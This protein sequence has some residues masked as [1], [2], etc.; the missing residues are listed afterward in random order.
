V[1]FR[2]LVAQADGPGVPVAD[3]GVAVTVT[4]V[5]P[6][7]GALEVLAEPADVDDE[8]GEDAQPT[9][10]VMQQTSAAA[11]QPARELP[12]LAFTTV[13]LTRVGAS[14]AALQV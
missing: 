8:L 6:A 9:N 10:A 13:P 11:A 2:E 4:V 5:V 3:E 7:A 1:T 12:A 14:R